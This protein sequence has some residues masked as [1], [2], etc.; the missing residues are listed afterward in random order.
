MGRS[1]AT[2]LLLLV[3]FVCGIGAHLLYQRW[4]KPETASEVFPGVFAP[5]PPMARPAAKDDAAEPPVVDVI[6]VERLRSLAGRVARIRGRVYNV[7]YSRKSNTHFLNFGPSRSSFTAVIFSD[8]LSRFQQ[9][10][11]QPKDYAGRELE[12]KGVVKNDE[13]YGLEMILDSPDQ[14]APLN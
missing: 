4:S 7:G 9:K 13:R 8:A 11:V 14:V 6:E 1:W 2:A 12:L 5:L 3:A 10:G